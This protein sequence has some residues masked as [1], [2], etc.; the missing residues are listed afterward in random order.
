MADIAGSGDLIVSKAPKFRQTRKGQ[1]R[2]HIINVKVRNEIGVLARIA[3]LIA[4]KG[5]NIE[6]LSVGE[7]HEPGISRM[8]IEVIGDDIVID[9]V[10]KQLR[11]LIDTL[12]V[13]DITDVPHVERE[14][15][16][17]KVH[18]PTAR[19][20]DEVLRI[21]EIFRG[22]IVDVS[23]ETY[24]IEVTGDEDKINAIIELLKPFG[25]KEMARTGKIAMRREL[26]TDE[27]ND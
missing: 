2:K 3:T 20:R 24:T 25:I 27:N 16:L 7:T 9:Q 18:T 17:I 19:A 4:G 23:P 10:V 21:T 6:S 26:F 8:T 11:K 14:L 12:K 5:Y 13:T 1:V 22:K 15:V